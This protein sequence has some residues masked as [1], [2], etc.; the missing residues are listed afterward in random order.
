MISLYEILNHLI[1]PRFLKLKQHRQ[2]FHDE[3]PAD[4]VFICYT[5]T[6][7]HP[8]SSLTLANPSSLVKNALLF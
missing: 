2:S 1:H 4:A 8:S 5:V 6:E 7:T 3:N